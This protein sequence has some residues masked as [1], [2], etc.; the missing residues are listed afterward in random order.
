M[1]PSLIANESNFLDTSLQLAN[2]FE[3]YLQK[4]TQ[5]QNYNKENMEIMIAVNEA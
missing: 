2:S 5:K 4:M 1:Y 3:V